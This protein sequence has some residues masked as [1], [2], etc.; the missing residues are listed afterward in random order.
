MFAPTVLP[1]APESV[2]AADVTSTSVL[3]ETQ[4]GFPMD[5]F[6]RPLDFEVS[7]TSPWDLQPKVG[8]HS[9]TCSDWR[10]AAEG[11]DSLSDL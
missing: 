9:V 10:P 3:L 2:E 7:Y 4:V 8:T 1:A 11:A 6:P 5:S